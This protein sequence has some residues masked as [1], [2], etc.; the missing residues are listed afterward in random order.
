MT[1]ESL[2]GPITTNEIASF[3]NYIQT[4]TPATWNTTGGMENEYA[5]GHSGEQAKAMG[6]MYELSHDTA[7]LDRMIVFCDVLLSQRNDLLAAPQGQKIYNTGTMAPAWPSSLTD[8]PIYST[9]AS[10]DCAGHLAYCARLI[11]QTP[12]SWDSSPSGG[13]SFGFGA[14]YLLRAKRYLAEADVCFDHYFFPYMLDLSSGN[15]LKYSASSPYQPGNQLPWNQALMMVYPLQNMAVAHE[16]LGDAPARVANY[17]TIVAVNVGRFFTDPAVKILYNDPDGQPAYNWSY[18]PT[19]NSGEDSNHGSLDVAGFYR[20]FRLG[21][22]GVTT[23]QMVPFA[24]MFCDVMTRTIG[25]DYA[26]T[27]S[28]TDGSGHAAPTTYVRSGFLFVAEFRPDQY[29]NLMIGSRLSAGGTTTSTDAFSR[30]M[31]EKQMR[32]LAAQAFALTLGPT[33]PAVVAGNTVNLAATITPHGTFNSSVNLTVT[34]LPPG[35]TTTITPAD[36]ASGNSTVAITTAANTAPGVYGV[37]VRGISGT[38]TQVASVDLYVSSTTQV[39]A[40]TFSP[41]GGTYTTVQ[42]V[43]LTTPTPGASIRYTT[44]GSTPTATIGTLYTAPIAINNSATVKAVAYASGMT[45]SLVSTATY[46]LNL[47]ATSAPVFSVPA[48]NY[49]SAQTVSLTSVT[50]GTSIRYTLDGSVP[51]TTNG[52]LYSGP[53]SVGYTTTLK[54]VAYASGFASSPLSTADYVIGGN[55]PVQIS[56]STIGMTDS[57]HATGFV[58][59]NTVDGSLSTRWASSGDGVWLQYDLGAVNTLNSLNIAWY[60]STARTYTFDLLVSLDGLNWTTVI[61]H[62]VTSG[63]TAGFES[64][65]F[66]PVVG[67]FVR[68]VGHLSNVDAYTNIV[69]LQLWGSPT[70]AGGVVAPPTFSPSP[71]TYVTA[72]TV[73]LSCATSGAAMRY[74]IDGTLPT[75]TTGTLYTGPFSVTTTA[76]VKTIAVATGLSDSA[77]AS[78]TYTIASGALPY[79]W[80]NTDIGGPALAGSSTYTNGVFTVKGAGADVWTQSDQFQYA[81]ATATGDATITARVATLQNTNVSAK[82]GVMFRETTAT[83]SRYVFMF[84]MPTKGVALQYRAAPTSNAVQLSTNTGLLAPYW[85]RLVRSGNAFTGYTSPDGLTWT[86]RGTITVNMTSTVMAGLGVCSH[87]TTTL[88]TGTFDNVA[89]ALTPVAAPAF[90]P[91]GGTYTSPQSVVM[92]T[93]T[94]GAAIYYT[95]DGTTPSATHGTLYSTPVTIDYG[96]TTLKA[97]AALAGLADSPVTSATYQIND[98][99]PPVLALP[100]NLVVEATGPNGAVVSFSGS[101]SDNVDEAVSVAFS[102]ASGSVFDLGTTLVTATA[103][104]VAGNQATGTFSV[105]VRDTT[106]PVLTP[107]ANL[108]LEATGPT[109][110]MATFS[111]SAV[112]LVNGSVPVGFSRSSGSVFPIGV[113]TVAA[114]ATD[115]SDNVTSRTFTVTVRDTTPPVLTVPTN[116]VAEAT[117]A[118]GA[119]VTFSASA[120][121][122]VN[123]SVAVSFSIAPGSMFPLG[124]TTVVAT[125]QDAAGNATSKSFTVTVRDTTAPA[126]TTLTASPNVIWPPNKQMVAVT[127]SPTATDAVGIASLKIKS[128][129]SNEAIPPTAVQITGPLSLNLQADRAGTATG[130]F[131]FITVEAK[132]AAGNTST[133]SVVAR[134]PHNL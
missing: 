29:Y 18:T 49:A 7:V 27:V 20:A 11:L 108:V 99:T 133:A 88:A 121:D 63:A 2:D 43:T 75:A 92:S 38:F 6:L 90:S 122:S 58:P 39:T 61:N 35:A 25:S 26:G 42:S 33:S 104:D 13:D 5:Q 3:R 59:A 74:T 78:A 19:A 8:S 69:E 73:S 44:D 56:N 67:Q 15:V 36:L 46:T 85:V 52:I 118:S 123:G 134:V 86:S 70:G 41:F 93:T 47:P 32:Y 110:A 87:A 127:L 96:T 119:A 64:Y 12:A 89:L 97:I 125:A 91:A 72:Q 120:S 1:V 129:T 83:N 60:L 101:A 9:S 84:L 28:G 117:G 24:N 14:T 115:A 102:P 45:N 130:R 131:Y 126:I 128:V 116:I 62:K 106:P 53:I 48:G 111:A 113:T 82:F 112:D 77:V 80:S 71:G 54:A 98:T 94:A 40:P 17:D 57:G 23:A 30:A 37:M 109:G 76:T 31:W 114:S 21:R 50:P 65:N 103:T 107:P 22:Y 132:D 16:I 4:L 10:G 105:T 81:S 95:T 66:S 100:N 34:G 55:T 79:G 51:S 68:V 124:T